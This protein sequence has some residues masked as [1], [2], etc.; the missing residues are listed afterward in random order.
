VPIAETLLVACYSCWGRGSPP[1]PPRNLRRLAAGVP[2]CMEVSSD[3]TDV[4]S[5]MQWSRPPSD[6]GS[7]QDVDD[8]FGD[9]WATGNFLL[10]PEH[11]NCG[12]ANSANEPITLDAVCKECVL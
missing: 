8:L 5:M 3:K 10:Q 9:L 2:A 6:V 1:P 4:C 12:C 11:V 7:G